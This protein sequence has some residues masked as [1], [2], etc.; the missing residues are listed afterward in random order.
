LI[1]SL[2]LAVLMAIQTCYILQ[3]V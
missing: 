2:D 1:V 3:C